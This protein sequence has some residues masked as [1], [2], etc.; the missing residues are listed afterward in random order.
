M[1]IDVKCSL[2]VKYPHYGK[3]AFRGMTED[4]VSWL[5]DLIVSMINNGIIQDYQ[6][7]SIRHY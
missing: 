1:K 6:I 7:E 5:T 3:I 2:A 4:E